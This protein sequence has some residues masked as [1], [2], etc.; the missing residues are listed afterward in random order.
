MILIE[1]GQQTISVSQKDK[2]FYAKD[3]EY[4]YSGCRLYVAK[5]NEDGSLEYVNHA[6]GTWKR[7]TYAELGVLEKGKYLIYVSV[8]WDEKTPEEDRFY[9]ITSYGV[10]GCHFNIIT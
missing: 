8:D 7:D 4:S 6:T 9:N 3:S 1:S 2:R 10:E 5:I